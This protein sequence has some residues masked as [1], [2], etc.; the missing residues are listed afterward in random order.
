MKLQDWT[1]FFSFF[2]QSSCIKE[3]VGKRRNTVGTHRNLTQEKQVHQTLQVHVCCQSKTHFVDI[4]FKEF[5]DK[6][7]MLFY[8]IDV[9]LPKTRCL[10]LHRPFFFM[11]QC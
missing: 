3:Q 7:G 5:S 4:R 1:S 10:Y 11:K 9:S 6:I 2:L 8:K